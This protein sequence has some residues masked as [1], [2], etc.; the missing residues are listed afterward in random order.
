[1]ENKPQPV[2]WALEE[3]NWRVIDPNK[4]K[5]FTERSDVP[6][7]QA[8]PRK[9]KVTTQQTAATKESTTNTQHTPATTQAAS[10]PSTREAELAGQEL[11]FVGADGT[12]YFDGKQSLNALRPDGTVVLWPLPVSAV[13]DGKVTLLQS[14]EGF[15]FLFNSPGRIVRIRPTPDEAEPFQV[16]ATFTR[17]VPNDAD[18]LRIWMDPANR[19]CIA[20]GN[21][22]T[23][24]FPIGRIS[25]GISEKMSP[26]DF[27]PDE[28]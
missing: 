13:G 25:P 15:L 27:P 4:E 2:P 18:P 10:A 6:K 9:A 12:Q 21:H 3:S 1:M 5:V 17:Q 19:I 7:I 20:H 8:P 23:I 16:E 22:V 11:I 28:P 24:L 14:K 26:Q